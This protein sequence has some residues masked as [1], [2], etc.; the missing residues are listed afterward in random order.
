[1]GEMGL[2]SWE[3]MFLA[4]HRIPSMC[5]NHLRPSS[6]SWPTEMI[7]WVSKNQLDILTSE[8]E[9]TGAGELMG[10]RRLA[11]LAGDITVRRWIRDM[12]VLRNEE[13]ELAR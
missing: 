8:T 11:W 7:F 2:G 4:W 10:H 13:E 1:M 9:I 3:W 12:L 6:V 5:H